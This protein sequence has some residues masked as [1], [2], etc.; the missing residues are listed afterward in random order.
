MSTSTQGPAGGRSRGP[1]LE[2]R[3]GGEG[4]IKELA[5]QGRDELA[6]SREGM[7]GDDDLGALL[8]PAARVERSVRADCM[9]AR[10][11][12]LHSSRCL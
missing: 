11:L 4:W 10:V 2:F 3:P 5:G 1:R 8:G 12:C 9:I 6:G 7:A